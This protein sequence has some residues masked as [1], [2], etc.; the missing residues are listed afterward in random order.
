MHP[1]IADLVSGYGDNFFITPAELNSTIIA[2]Q[3]A[4][5]AVLIT[6]NQ[7]ISG[8][9]TFA[10]RPT[11]NGTV[12]LL[13]GEVAAQLPNTIVYKTGDQTISGVKTFATKIEIGDFSN[14]IYID[15]DGLVISGYQTTLRTLKLIAASPSYETSILFGPGSD[16]LTFRSPNYTFYD[17]RPKI[18]DTGDFT[19][20]AVALLDEVVLNTGNQTISGAKTFASRPIVNGTGVLLSGEAVAVAQLPNT[21]VYTTGNQ[22]IGGYKIFTG[23]G[24]TL[25]VGGYN[26]LNGA[27]IGNTSLRAHSVFVGATSSTTINHIL[28]LS[29]LPGNFQSSEVFANPVST[30]LNQNNVAFTTGN[31]TISGVKN[32]TSRPTVNGTGVLL[33]GS[34]PFVLTYGHP[35]D[36][37]TSG[38]VRRYFGPPLDIG[39]VSLG[40]N[41]KRRSRILEDCFLREVSWAVIARDN[42]PTPS[43]AMTGY[44]KNFGNNP[45]GNDSSVGNQVTPAIN[46]PTINE[47]YNYST[48]NLNIPVKS[49]DYVS[50]YYQ[51]NYTPGSNN[52]ASGLAVSVDAYFY[53]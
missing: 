7:T 5:G 41:E 27:Y 21:I 28:G 4:Q 2:A 3:S 17:T 19:S 52:L 51:T 18:L 45:L 39:P 24:N 8:I 15:P 12:V 20:R 13:S 30:I 47:I 32:F 49:G 23:V 50:F 9:K 10:S 29:T 44:F 46:L 53:V 34:T 25:Q 33:S 16:G 48:G 35:R 43:N 37:T 14:A 38:D 22:A 11:V 40:S 6:G 31:Q 42:F 1:D 36:N 26:L